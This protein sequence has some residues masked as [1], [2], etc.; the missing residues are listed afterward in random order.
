MLTWE[1]I[2]KTFEAEKILFPLFFQGLTLVEKELQIYPHGLTGERIKLFFFFF[3]PSTVYCF[4]SSAS[5]I[6]KD[7]CIRSLIFQK[8]FQGQLS[9]TKRH[10]TVA[11]FL[12][13]WL[14]RSK[15]LLFTFALEL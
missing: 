14:V 6:P 3:K 7:A 8:H 15:V 13:D 12:T 4:L 5:V 10:C 2:R 9:K 1:N 11:T